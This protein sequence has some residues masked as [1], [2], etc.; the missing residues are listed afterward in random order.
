MSYQSSLGKKPDVK[1]PPVAQANR[2]DV[3]S[4]ESAN[5]SFRE[6]EDALE[7]V[8]TPSQV[9]KE[10]KGSST[11][12]DSGSEKKDNGISSSDSESSEAKKTEEAKQIESEES[13]SEEDSSKE[14]NAVVVQEDL[15]SA[16]STDS[17]RLAHDRTV[18][19][20]PGQVADSPTNLE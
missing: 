6:E 12:E 3:Q 13:S 20:K 4:T 10:S 9:E 7:K 19:L 14:R 15:S 18:L 1:K 8:P 2:G 16:K 11:D 5:Y 17:L